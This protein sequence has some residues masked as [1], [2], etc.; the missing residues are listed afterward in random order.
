M[1]KVKSPAKRGE[2]SARAARA[3]VKAVVSRGSKPEKV[4]KGQDITMGDK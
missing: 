4:A 2:I 3:A 1:Q